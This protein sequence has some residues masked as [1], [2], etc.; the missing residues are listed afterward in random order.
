MGSRAAGAERI[1]RGEK[2]LEPVPSRDLRPWRCSAKQKQRGGRQISSVSGRPS[3]NM[4]ETEPQQEQLASQGT[5][6]GSRRETLAE[7][8]GRGAGIGTAT[9]EQ[10]LRSREAG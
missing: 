7:E 9:D 2:R 6:A 10:A 5:D 4:T 1:A 8:I 3:P